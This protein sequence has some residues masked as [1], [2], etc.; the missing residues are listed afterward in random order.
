MFEFTKKL[1]VAAMNTISLA[2]VGCGV[3]ISSNPIKCILMSNQECKVRPI[4]VNISRNESDFYLYSVA[5][6]KSSGTCNDIN[7]PFSK[8]CVP[9]VVKNMNIKVFETHYDT[10][11]V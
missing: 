5:T 3:L 11:Y 2:F 4:T 1:F 7:N 8:L 6:N 10:R 9:D